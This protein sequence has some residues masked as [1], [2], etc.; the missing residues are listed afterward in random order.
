M[1]TLFARATACCTPGFA[2]MT[3]SATIYRMVLPDHVCP[4]GLAAKAMLEECGYEV[5]DR[6]LT[7]RDEVDAFKAERGLAT[8]PFILV[9]GREVRGAEELDEY[10]RDKR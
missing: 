8:T 7:T 2:G 4:F 10:L 1:Q 3:R 9:D 6:Q 5:E